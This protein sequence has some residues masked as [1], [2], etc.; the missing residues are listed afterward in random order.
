[1]KL[2]DINGFSTMNEYPDIEHYGVKGQKWGVR[3][4][5]NPDGSYT[6]LGLSRF[7]NRKML[8]QALKDENRKAYQLGR[9]ATIAARAVKYSKQNDDKA[10]ER[11]AKAKAEGADDAKIAKLTEKARLTAKTL[12]LSEKI[13]EKKKEAAKTHLDE[14]IFQYG[15]SSVKGIKYDENGNVS[16]SLKLGKLLVDKQ[17]RDLGTMR[18]NK[19]AKNFAKS[20]ARM[21]VETE[22]FE[23]REAKHAAKKK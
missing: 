3:R 17:L 18:W 20:T 12:D 10:K 19:A 7:K 22:K 21:I 14:L 6:D 5:Q 4:Y 8:K 15:A 9:E 2:F 1:M 11:L 16:E 23:K 13:R